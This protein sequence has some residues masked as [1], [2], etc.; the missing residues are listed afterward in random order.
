MRKCDGHFLRKDSYYFRKKPHKNHDKLDIL[1]RLMFHLN[2]HEQRREEKQ[3]KFQESYVLVLL[4]STWYTSNATIIFSYEKVLLF[5]HAVDIWIRVVVQPRTT[6][7]NWHLKNKLNFTVVSQKLNSELKANIFRKSIQFSSKQGCFLHALP[8]W[9]HGRG[10]CPPQPP[11]P[12]P[13]A[14]WAQRVKSYNNSYSKGLPK[15]CSISEQWN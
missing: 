12:L 10:L 9:V 8:T 14:R 6:L 3:E 15:G 11:L 13:A 4:I 1:S 5:Y 7:K 2:I